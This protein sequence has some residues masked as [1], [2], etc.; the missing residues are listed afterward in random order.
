M[1]RMILIVL[2][3]P[4]IKLQA[5]T[6]PKLTIPSTPAFSI[7]DYEPTAVMRPAT[8]KD[9]AADVLNSFDRDGKL[10]MNLGLEVSP[11]WL[12]SHSTLT[13][14]D[15]LDPGFGQTF[16]QS[17]NLSA[18]TV[19]DSST[20][21]NKLGV[22]F[23]FKL[24]DGNPVKSLEKYEAEYRMQTTIISTIG[25][26]RRMIGDEIKSRQDAIDII[27]AA[28]NSAGI[29]E[30]TVSRFRQEAAE[31]A[32]G[33]TDS[34]ADIRLFL[35]RMIIQ[36]TNA[37]GELYSKV[38]EIQY[39]RTGF[40]LEFAGAGG[41]KT[42]NDRSVQ[43]IGIWMNASNYFSPDDLITLTARFMHQNKD[44]AQNNFDVGVGFLRKTAS[45][46]LSLEGMFRWYRA[47]IHDVN[48]NNQPIIRLEK[49]F[50]YRIAIQGSYF[51]SRDISIN[52]NIGKEFDS[53]FISRSG[54]FSILGLN[55]S[56][57]NKQKVEL[58]DPP[59]M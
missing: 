43:K 19:R 3:L 57:F 28:L 38:A 17:F 54:F 40:I 53:P 59:A 27:I 46:N 56:I 1:I 18:A 31:T 22:G 48:V 29:A 45:Y 58:P 33:Y 50:T 34:Q 37:N 51:I 15:Y 30:E 4:C 14:G 8:N 11:Y 25:S 36:R 7:L 10:L 24:A 35:E 26:A 12:K 13:R 42:N 9:L 5:Q 2:V 47:E 49:D 23:R 44:T 39:E 21:D 16:L 32:A 52:L 20:G 41:F 55:Y 6:T